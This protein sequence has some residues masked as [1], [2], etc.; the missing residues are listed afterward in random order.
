MLPSTG[1]NAYKAGEFDFLHQNSIPPAEV[2][3]LI[4]EN[5]EFYVYPLLG[6]YYYNFN[7]D[8]EM[9]QDVRIR[10]AL[11]YAIDRDKIVETKASGEV[12]AAGFIPPGFPDADGKDFFE[13]S[14]YLWCINR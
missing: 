7:M 10:K 11:A 14:R 13:N 8:L 5:P 6:T 2:P 4:A 1:Y 12:P 9:W 3:A